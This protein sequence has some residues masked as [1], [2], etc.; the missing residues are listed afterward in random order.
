MTVPVLAFPFSRFKTRRAFE[1][2]QDEMR[3]EFR[4]ESVSV[5]TLVAIGKGNPRA[6]HTEFQN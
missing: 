1:K 6:I 4:L 5:E 2:T 3:R